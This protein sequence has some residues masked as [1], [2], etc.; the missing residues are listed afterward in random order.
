M[1]TRHLAILRF[2]PGG[3]AVTG[4]W[5]TPGPAEAAYLTWIGLHTKDHN[6][7]VTVELLEEHDGTTRTLRKWAGD[8]EVIAPP[9]P[10]A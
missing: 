10:P 6:P 7:E 3:P 5:T 2:H 8:H 9:D 4:H 1:T